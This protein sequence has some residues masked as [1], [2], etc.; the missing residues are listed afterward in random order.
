[1]IQ[2]APTESRDEFVETDSL[3]SER[4]PDNSIGRLFADKVSCLVDI[5]ASIDSDASARLKLSASVL[6]EIERQYCYLKTKL[7]E[8][9]TWGLGVNR[10][11]DSRRSKLEMQLDK[12]N[13]ETRQERVQAWQNVE[14]L[15]KE[16]RIWFKQYCDLVQRLRIVGVKFKAQPVLPS[17]EWRSGGGR[18]R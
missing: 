15:R 10:N 18:N 17:N 12:L 8:L 5:L 2:Y 14:D 16:W 13:Q 4:Q 7:Y 11:V 9:D 1:M 6:V 3:R